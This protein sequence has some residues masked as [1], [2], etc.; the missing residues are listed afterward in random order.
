LGLGWVVAPIIQNL[1][2]E[3][4]VSTLEATRQALQTGAK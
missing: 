1:P 2:K 4:L 3:S